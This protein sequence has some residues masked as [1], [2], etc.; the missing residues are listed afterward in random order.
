[1]ETG[2]KLTG[3]EITP[4]FI[5]ENEQ[6]QPEEPLIDSH[7]INDQQAQENSKKALLNPKYTFDTFVIGKGN[8]MAHA[9]CVGRSRRSGFYL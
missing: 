2:F 1:M 5:I 6:P 9:A 7:T 4:V 8:Q 3:E